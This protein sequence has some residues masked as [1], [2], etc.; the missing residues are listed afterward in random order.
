M[1]NLTH[2]W[3]EQN[4]FDPDYLPE[5]A[6]KLYFE[7]D[8]AL[9]KLT[10]YAVLLLLATVISTYGVTSD[11]TATVIGAMLVAP[12]MTPIM[13]TTLALVMGDERLA[14][15]SLLL[16]IISVTAVIGLAILLSF[17]IGFMNYTE[18]G[19]ISS[20]VEPGLSAMAVALAAGAAGAF[21]TSR[22]SIGDSLPGVAVSIALVPPLSVVGIALSDGQFDDA[23]GAFLLFF[24]NFLAIILAGGVVFWVS[25]AN[26]LNLTESQAEGRKR[27]FVVAIIS[28]IIVTLMLATT[29]FNAYRE[30]RQINEATAVTQEWLAESDYELLNI[31]VRYP[32]VTITVAGDGDL[33]PVAELGQALNDRM[34]VELSSLLVKKMIRE[35][36]AYPEMIEP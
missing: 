9:R 6:N 22:R 19:E 26:A 20:R 8:L 17:P 32:A 33:A 12:L 7:G 2:E 28:S 10:S 14:I 23:F 16:V 31:I 29:S 21:A 5:I 25:G 1:V 24:T 35:I 36:E 11:S 30:S 34:H 18:N 27:A 4:R 3:F 15:R 13:G